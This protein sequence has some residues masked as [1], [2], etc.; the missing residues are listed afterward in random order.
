MDEQKTTQNEIKNILNNKNKT[1][2]KTD[3]YDD[4]DSGKNKEVENV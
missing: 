4:V 3:D 2:Q 1:K